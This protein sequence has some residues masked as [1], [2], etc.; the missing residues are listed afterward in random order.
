MKTKF[1]PRMAAAALALNS[2][3][4]LFYILT[5]FFETFQA[6]NRIVFWRL[7]WF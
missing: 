6:F 3:L 7:F 5:P 1:T 4:Y 2:G